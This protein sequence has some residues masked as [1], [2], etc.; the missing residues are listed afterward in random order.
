MAKNIQPIPTFILGVWFGKGGKSA[1]SS[2]EGFL[3]TGGERE[4]LIL[5]EFEDQSCRSY[6]AYDSPLVG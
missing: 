2:G 4:T 3:G 5:S 1:F 6:W